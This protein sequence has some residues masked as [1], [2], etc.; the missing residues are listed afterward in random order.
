MI[1]I[2]HG[3]DLPL[4]RKYIIGLQAKLNSQNK[5]E[6]KIKDYTPAAL[7]NLISSP[8]FFGE[9]PLIILDITDAARMNVDEYIKVLKDNSG[10]KKL[11]LIIYSGKELSEKNEFIKNAGALKAQIKLTQVIP[12]HN[13]FAFTAAMLNLNRT[14]TYRELSKLVNG[15]QDGYFIYSMI[16]SAVRNMTEAKLNT[17]NFL[18]MK[19]YSQQKLTSQMKSFSEN[20]IMGIYKTLYETDKATKTGSLDIDLGVIL[21]IEKIL[22]CSLPTVRKSI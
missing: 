8:D 15:D 17:E 20:Q 1:F 18:K 21:A 5:Q 9:F 3:E 6:I 12:E 7:S 22:S 16:I 14:Q 10:N 13:V 11:S 2:I 4:S 19:P